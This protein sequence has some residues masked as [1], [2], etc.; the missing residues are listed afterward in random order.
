MAKTLAPPK[1][2]CRRC[3]GELSYDE[4]RDC[5]YCPICYPPN[6]V[7]PAQIKE[8]PKYID[9][10]MTEARVREIVKDEMMGSKFDEGQIRDIVRDELENWHIQKPSITKEDV[11]E[12]ATEADTKIAEARAF[13]ANET[14]KTTD[15]RQ[16]AKAL[17]IPLFQRKK[18]DVLA[19]IA[20]KTKGTADGL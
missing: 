10:A 7:Q 2:K 18:A 4:K 1:Q 15:W 19:E 8:K 14:K 13:A 17:G 16:E 20:S 12:L 9:V 11:K 6:R 5:S 3:N